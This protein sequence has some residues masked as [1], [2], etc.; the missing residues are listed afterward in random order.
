[1][2]VM[3]NVL[4]FVVNYGYKRIVLLKKVSYLLVL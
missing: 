4:M 2:V 1:M 3:R